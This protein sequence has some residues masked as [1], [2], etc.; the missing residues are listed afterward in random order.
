MICHGQVEREINRD[1]SKVTVCC[2]H[3]RYFVLSTV[4]PDVRYLLDRCL[5]FPTWRKEKDHES[6]SYSTPGMEYVHHLL[7]RSVHCLFFCS[8]YCCLCWPHH[9]AAAGNHAL[10]LAQSFHA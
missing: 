1:G 3:L 8:C 5:L 9:E 2:I 7:N 10:D 6:A 4:C